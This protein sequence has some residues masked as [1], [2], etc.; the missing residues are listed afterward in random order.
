M[1]KVVRKKAASKKAAKR[2]ATRIIRGV[3]FESVRRAALA[4]PGVEEGTS[5]GTPAFR[6]KK[7]LFA[8]MREEGE[9]FVL[10]VGDD[11]RDVLLATE[12]AVFHQT[13]HYFGHPYVLA[14]LGAITEPRL[15]SIVEE[16]WRSVAPARLVAAIDAGD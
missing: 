2:K 13:P 4:L 8:R 11:L 6:V 12:S 1:K 7:K 16:A 14:R 15:A 9:D 3:D 10:R 5:Y